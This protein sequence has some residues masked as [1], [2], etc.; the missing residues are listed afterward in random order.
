MVTVADVTRDPLPMRYHRLATP[1][2]ES[3]ALIWIVTGTVVHCP[4]YV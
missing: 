2:R 4:E 1:L 3:V